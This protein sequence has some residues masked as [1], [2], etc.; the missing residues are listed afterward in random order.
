MIFCSHHSN[1]LQEFI[2]DMESLS[3]ITFKVMTYKDYWNIYENDSIVG[4]KIKLARKRY[5]VRIG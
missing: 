3:S 5:E 2:K 1:E 4:E